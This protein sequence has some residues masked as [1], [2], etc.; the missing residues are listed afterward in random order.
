MRRLRFDALR[1][2]RIVFLFAAAAAAFL[3]LGCASGAPRESA[4]SRFAEVK[5]YIAA[6]E[7][8]AVTVSGRIT[9]GCV[10]AREN[11]ELAARFMAAIKDA[12]LVPPFEKG[13][14]ALITSTWD[15]K[16]NF[17][18]TNQETFALEF[19]HGFGMAA[20]DAELKAARPRTGTFYSPRYD[21]FFV[22][23][24]LERLAAEIPQE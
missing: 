16:L 13:E 6:G 7:L 19:Y 17:T 18:F 14:N 21:V 9:N 10:R 12:E 24:P 2:D 15:A 4:L 11:P 3:L 5:R 1:S 23:R 22:S 20:K 8:D